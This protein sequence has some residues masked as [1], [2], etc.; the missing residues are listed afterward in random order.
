MLGEHTVLGTGDT[1]DEALSNVREGLTG[2]MAYL[3][4]QGEALSPTAI[5]VVTI[6]IAA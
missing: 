2:I 6:E 1:R 5:E 3:R 4:E